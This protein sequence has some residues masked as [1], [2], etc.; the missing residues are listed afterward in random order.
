MA[1]TSA[2]GIIRGIRKE[3][4]LSSLYTSQ[5]PGSQLGIVAPDAAGCMWNY[6][7]LLSTSAEL[8]FETGIGWLVPH[9]RTRDDHLHK[10]GIIFSIRVR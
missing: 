5:I 9:C 7:W 6:W 1:T 4:M 10:S 8:P 2:A 3:F